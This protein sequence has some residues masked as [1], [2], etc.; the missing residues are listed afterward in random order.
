MRCLACNDPLTPHAD[1]THYRFSR[2]TH[3]GRACAQITANAKRRGRSVLLSEDNVRSIRSQLELGMP[4]AEIAPQ[5]G[6]AEA[7]IYNIKC[8]Y[9]WRHV[10]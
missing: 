1:E 10:T 4:V 6:V 2:R 3:C 5:Y 9:T 7:T 8:G